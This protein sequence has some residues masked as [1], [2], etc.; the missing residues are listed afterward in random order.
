MSILL[1]VVLGIGSIIIY[2]WLSIRAMN[3]VTKDLQDWINRG[4]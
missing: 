4:M 2:K 3:K 1:I